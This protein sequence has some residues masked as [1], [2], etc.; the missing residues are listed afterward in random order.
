MEQIRR[1]LFETNSS[2][3]HSLTFCTDDEYSKWKNGELLYNKWKKKFVEPSKATEYNEED[4]YSFGQFWNSIE[5]YY[6]VFAQEYTTP[7]GETVVAFGFYGEN[8]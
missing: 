2:S 6:E 4:L 8:D 1:G 3:V 5:N 7:G